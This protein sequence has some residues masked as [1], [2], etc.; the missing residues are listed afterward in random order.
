[1]ADFGVFGLRFCH[2]QMFT[3]RLYFINW[4]HGMIY[5]LL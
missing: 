3:R 4:I 2:Y 1:L 5:Y